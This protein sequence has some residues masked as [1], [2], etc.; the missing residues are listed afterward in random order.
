ME[1]ETDSD[2]GP[3][4]LERGPV[5]FNQRARTQNNKND[6]PN[7]NIKVTSGAGGNSL[8]ASRAGLRRAGAQQMNE[9]RAE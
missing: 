4:P 1:P 2:D 5:H 8:R 9:N 3:P 6:K 7:I